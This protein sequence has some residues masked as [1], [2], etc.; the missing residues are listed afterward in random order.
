MTPR[1]LGRKTFGHEVVNIA[2]ALGHSLMP[3]QQHWALVCGEVVR[4][5]ETGIW[6]PAYGEAMDTTPRQS[7]KTLLKVA[8]YLHRAFMWE[9]WDGKPQSIAFSGQTGALARQKFSEEHWPMINASPIR[10]KIARPRFAAEKSG[11][12][13]KNGSHMT[14]WASS[15]QSGH[16]LT[17]DMAIMDEIWA[18]QDERREQSAV[19]AMATRHDRQKLLSSTGGTDA[20]VLYLRKQRNGR[21]AVEEGRTEGIAYVEYSADPTVEGFDPEDSKLWREVMPALGFTITERTVQSA[22]DEMR[23]PDGDL[24]EFMRAWLNVTNR[25]TG[26]VVIDPMLWTAAQDHD[27]APAGGL[28]L[29]VDAQPDQSTAAIV[30]CDDRLR[31]EVVEHRA[32]TSWLV[33]RLDGI[34]A[35]TAAEVVV[36]VGGPVGFLADQLEKR[37]VTVYRAGTRDV[38]HATQ[39]FMDRFKD[40]ELHIRPYPALDAAA[41]AAV[42]QTVGDGWKWSRKTVQADISPLVAATLAVGRQLA[43]PESSDLYVSFG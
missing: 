33:N 34:A 40:R 10:T 13:F 42:K 17:I 30:V 12:D 9:A 41:K 2:E 38:V 11:L 3:W 14:I 6:V 37:G 31:L 8:Q 26:T 19:P 32:G 25:Q 27:A 4:D 16:S 23:G 28:V 18:D 5:E 15:A 36:D 22:L 7:G 1:T 21:A 43:A 24:S 35:E 29:G 39:A 20:S